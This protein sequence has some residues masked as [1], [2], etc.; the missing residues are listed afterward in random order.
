MVSK[1]KVRFYDNYTPV[2]KKP[3]APAERGLFWRSGIQMS[4]IQMKKCQNLFSYPWK[5]IWESY[6]R[7]SIL[8]YAKNSF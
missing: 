5:M 2:G 4:G 3:F 7:S 6:N 8:Y 1:E